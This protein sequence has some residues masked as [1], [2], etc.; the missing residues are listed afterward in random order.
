MNPNN[1]ALN[2]ANNATYDVIDDTVN[3]LYGSDGLLKDEFIHFGAD[4]VV[5]YC[6]TQT[7]EITEWMKSMG[8]TTYDQVY[9]YFVQRVIRQTLNNYGDK[10]NKII[11]WNDAYD[12]FGSKLDNK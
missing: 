9:Q 11:H 7:E 5:Y 3:E 8:F 1:I 6:W 10:N 12:T 4:E 2:P